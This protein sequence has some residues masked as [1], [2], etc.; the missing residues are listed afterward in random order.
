MTQQQHSARLSTLEQ[1]KLATDAGQAAI[2]KYQHNQERLKQNK[3]KSEIIK[4]IGPFVISL[5][6]LVYALI[7]YLGKK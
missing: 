3:T 7:Q 2:E 5:T 6:L 4:I 1:W